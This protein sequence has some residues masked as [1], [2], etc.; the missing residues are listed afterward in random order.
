[1]PKPGEIKT[2]ELQ[3]LLD[4]AVSRGQKSLVIPPGYYRVSQ[5]VKL[6]GVIDF[7]IEGYGATLMFPP[8]G[9]IFA[10][11]NCTRLSLKGFSV[12]C[13]P[14]PFTQGTITR[15]SDDFSSFEYEIHSGYPQLNS[16]R[17]E[18]NGKNGVFVFAPGTLR[19]RQDI[20]DLYPKTS[21]ILSPTQG[22]ITLS[23]NL[24]GYRNIR[25]GDLVAFKNGGGNAMLFRGCD[26][27]RL[28]DVTVLTA[29]LAGFLLR[30]CTGPV[31]LS[32]CVIKKG[33][34]PA[35]ATNPRLLSTEADGFN[36]GYSR[37]GATLESCDFSFMGDDSVNLHGTIL[38]VAKVIDPKIFWVAR[39]GSAEFQAAMRPGDT[40]RFMDPKSFAVKFTSPISAC[41]V[42]KPE[43]E[44]EAAIRKSI[45]APADQRLFFVRFTLEKP[46][47]VAAGDK[48]EIPEIA[49]PNFVFRNNYFHDHRARGLRLGASHG[50]IEDNRFERLKSTAISLGPH[51]I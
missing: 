47:A 51:A 21:E 24:P 27:V 37:Q 50:V 1:M 44:L 6:A 15:V 26:D 12:D 30:S 40:A 46:V 42:L 5:K 20:P 23:G 19:W 22:R 29:P 8:E 38:D 43:P 36:I 41:E 32:H 16:P 3:Q 39:T 31:L 17:Y 9:E 25:V 33:P 4:D 10:F 35:G 49:C 48:L 34:T 18:K 7:A 45:K 2:L 28:K 11:V 14:L 13:D